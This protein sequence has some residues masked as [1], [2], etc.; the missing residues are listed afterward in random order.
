M[1]LL[2]CQKHKVGSPTATSFFC[3]SRASSVW[4]WY[5]FCEVAAEETPALTV[6][7]E[8]PK[9]GSRLRSIIM[10]I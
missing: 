10:L 1:F 5:L 3:H 6:A 2:G 8:N 9:E 7:N 4:T